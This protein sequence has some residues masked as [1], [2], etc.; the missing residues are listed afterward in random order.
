ML[1]LWYPHFLALSDLT[2]FDHKSPISWGNSGYLRFSS[3]WPFGRLADRFLA[4]GLDFGRFGPKTAFLDPKRATLGNR[5]HETGRQA[6]KRPPT[7][8]PKVSR[9]TSGYGGLMIQSEGGLG[10][11]FPYILKILP[12]IQCILCKNDSYSDHEWKTTK[13]TACPT[14]H[15]RSDSSNVL[16]L[17][18][19]LKGSSVAL[20]V[21]GYFDS[22]VSWY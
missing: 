6:A 12:F 9:V 13:N 20:F 4:S 16:V 17:S 15:R 18:P 22:L 19:E 1:H 7:G 10:V 5:G 21:M 2:Q 11:D 14:A 8:K 3:R